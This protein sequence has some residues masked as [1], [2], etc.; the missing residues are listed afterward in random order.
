MKRADEA[1]PDPVPG[2]RP[3]RRP[4]QAPAIEESSEFETLALACGLTAGPS[5]IRG[6]G[7]QN[8]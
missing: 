7:L 6:G 8:S 5:C 1:S 3:R 4:Y 2:E